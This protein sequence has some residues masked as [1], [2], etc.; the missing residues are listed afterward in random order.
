MSFLD[1]LR[2]LS[3]MARRLVLMRFFV[4]LGIQCAYFIGVVGTLTYALDGGVGDNA[5]GVALLNLTL[6]VGSF[7]G[8]P[9]LDR[10]GPRRY[11]ALVVAALV[12]AAVAFQPLSGSACSVFAGAAILGTAMGMADLVAKSFPAYLTGDLDELKRINSAVYTVSNVAV[13]VGPLLGGT[14]A[15]ALST[16]SVFLLLGIC[17]LVS[18]VPALG[19]RPVRSATAPNDAEEA[20]PG[21]GRGFRTVFSTP[22]LALLF[23]S[24][25]LAF[26][27]YGAFDP[28]ESLYYRDVLNVG[29]EWMGWLSSAAG[30]GGV[31]GSLLAMRLPARHANMRTLLVILA[32]QGI[33]CVAY[34][35][36]PWVAVACAGQALLGVAFGMLMPL[37]ATLVQR[38]APLSALGRVNSVM[39]FGN[40]VA[41][42][43]P[44]LCAP[45]LSRVLGVQG[46]LLAASVFVFAM[47]LLIGV[48][49]RAEVSALVAQEEDE[50]GR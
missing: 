27:G 32:S 43:I 44:L 40:N 18:V 36:T 28:L 3:P 49:R 24:C 34:V 41:G 38:H 14:L 19:F 30:V 50:T 11:F 48:T 15:A 26:F 7:V 9:L 20:S 2:A 8:G 31:V 47:P 35:G 12:L 17:A 33:S 25:F 29:V 4:Y 5:L 1:T 6:I 23:W 22:A 42:V 13:V 45:L 21:L 37:H 46:T 39:N 16:S 10:M